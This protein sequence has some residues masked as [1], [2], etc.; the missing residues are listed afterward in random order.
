MVRF[1]RVLLRHKRHLSIKIQGHVAPRTLGRQGMLAS[2]GTL[3][4]VAPA[5]HSCRRSSGVERVIGN[6]EVHS[7][8]LCGGT[9]LSCHI[10]GSKAPNTVLDFKKKLQSDT[11]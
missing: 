8:I 11:T 5:S 10:V 9:I 2:P 4:H 1:N 6:D 7:S 3:W